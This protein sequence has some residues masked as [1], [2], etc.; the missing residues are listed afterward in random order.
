M[1][2]HG[3]R[4]RARQPRTAGPREQRHD[5]GCDE[6][7]SAYSSNLTLPFVRR[8]HKPQVPCTQL[9]LGPPVDH[10]LRTQ[11]AWRLRLE[12]PMARYTLVYGVRLIPEGSL[13]ALDDAK[14]T[15][16]DG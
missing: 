6:T 2:G 11:V 10:S 15:L 7:S 12:W 4:R 3:G 13:K 14:I 16:S 1:P 5:D 9:S 8:D